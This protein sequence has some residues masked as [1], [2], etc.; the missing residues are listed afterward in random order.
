MTGV[1]KII[2]GDTLR[3][4]NT[5]IRLHGIDA[6]EAK[7]TCN[8][9]GKEWRCG[10]EATNALVR[11]VGERQVTCSQ[12]DVDRYGRIVAVCRAGAVDLNAWMVGEGWAVAYR[13]FS[14][15]YVSDESEAK[16][17]GNGMWRGE[18]MMPWDWRRRS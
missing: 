4:G 13:R 3:I 11:I 8:V 5:R 18:F 17:A 15:E 16:K 12:R 10:Q 14:R 2:D 9:D 7:Q 1:P 6:P